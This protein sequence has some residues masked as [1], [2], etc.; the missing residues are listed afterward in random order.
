MTLAS[1]FGSDSRRKIQA[2][3]DLQQKYKTTIN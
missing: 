3:T 2:D 1:A